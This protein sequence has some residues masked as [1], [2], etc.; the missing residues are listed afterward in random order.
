MFWGWTS[1]LNKYLQL[2][3]LKGCRIFNLN[4][5]AHTSEVIHCIDAGTSYKWI[6]GPE[7]PHNLS[8]AFLNTWQMPALMSF[9]PI[10]LIPQ[11]S[12]AHRENHI[13][14]RT[15]H[16]SLLKSLYLRFTQRHGLHSLQLGTIL[17]EYSQ[18]HTS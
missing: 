9:K 8:N 14:N 1:A 13:P 2:L 17:N 15:D 7:L 10:L 6:T 16:R 3:S 4:F 11:S 5:N 12:Q 18:S